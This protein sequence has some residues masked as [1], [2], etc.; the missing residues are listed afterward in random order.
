VI[1][2]SQ[3]FRLAEEL[4]NL[5]K[6]MGEVA[7]ACDSLAVQRLDV[8][9]KLQAVEI[10]LNELRQSIRHKKQAYDQYVPV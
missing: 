9:V 5:M 10:Q 6:P 2:Q 4:L 8:K 1:S 7:L 3:L